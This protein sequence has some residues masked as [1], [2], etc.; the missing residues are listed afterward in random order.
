M[1][2]LFV[3][4]G[5]QS[6]VKKDLD[7]LNGAHDVRCLHFKGIND[8]QAVFNGSVWADLTFSW[9]GKLHAFF[10]VLFSKLM[11]KKAVVV[12]G[13]DDVA[14]EPDIKYGMSSYWWKKWCPLFIFRYADLILCVSKFN[15][16]EAIKNI[17]ADSKK[18][19]MIYHGFDEQKFRPLKDVHK[20][21]YVITVGGVNRERMIRKGY[22]VFIRSAVLLPTTKFVLM[23]KWQDETINYLRQIAPG[24]VIFTGEVTEYELISWLNRSKVYLQISRHEA[25][26]CSL[27]EAM[28]CKCVPVVSRRGALEEVVGECGFYVNDMAPEEVAKQIGRALASDLGSRARERI[29]YNFS[30]KKRQA[31]LLSAIHNLTN[32]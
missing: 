16:N 21:N 4:Q 28:L 7:I 20:E 5:L 6:F 24:N 26:G 3:H 8:I 25:F 19:N 15:L 32:Q 23:G 14:Y 10:T 1:K 27:A 18:I 22:E 30:L 13:G 31:A 12:A 11:K 2:I 17:R 29:Y 9:F